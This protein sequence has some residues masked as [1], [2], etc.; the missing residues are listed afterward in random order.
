MKLVRFLVTAFL[1][2]VVYLLLVGS[3]SVAEV[4]LAVVVGSGAA[5]LI[6]PLFLFEAGALD[7]RRIMRGLAYVPFFLWQMIVANL[8]IALVVLNPAMPV[9]P[10]I[11][12]AKT[13]LS[14]PA[15]KLLLTSS[16]TLTP[17]TLAVDAKD[18]DLY[19]HCVQAT[20]EDEE[21][22]EE[23]IVEKFQKRLEGVTE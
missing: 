10:S 9:R 16:I 6:A 17:G 22:P 2:A 7:P 13:R 14:S 5:A 11:V 3:L 12:R 1:S 15:G 23:V 21:E 20:Q 8:R 19:I 4:I 18:D